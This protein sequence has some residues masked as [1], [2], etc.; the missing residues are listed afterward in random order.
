MKE[1][2]ELVELANRANIAGQGT[3]DMADFRVTASPDKILAIAEELRALEQ[4]KAAYNEWHKKTEWVQTDKR[5]EV[6]IPWGKHRAD[7]LREYIERLEGKL[8]VLKQQQP[9]GRVDRGAATDSN[10]YPDARVVCLHEY[11]GWENVQDGTE[12]FLRPAPAISL[13]ELVL[14]Q[15]EVEN[16]LK[17]HG[18]RTKADGHSQ[19]SDAFR[20]GVSY[21]E[22]H[23][24]R[25]IEEAK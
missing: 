10:E 15:D 5:F 7:V 17:L 3:R 8:E 12:L 2:N 4:F 20:A 14:N 19:L 25:K 11:A 9:I 6:L 24:L 22:S 18:L 13:A 16:A 1:L 21:Q 23:I